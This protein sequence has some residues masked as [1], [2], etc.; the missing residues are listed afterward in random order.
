M[1]LNFSGSVAL[2]T[3]AG[4]GIGK[5]TAIAFAREGLK[6]VVADV[7]SQAGEACVA[8]I[9][10]QGGQALFVH[11][12][13][14]QDASVKAMIDATISAFGRLDYAFNNAGI[15]IEQGDRLPDGTDAEFDAIMNV[16]VKGV[17]NCLRHQLPLMMRQ[18]GGAIV[19][20]ASIA[21]L[22]AA[23]KM[24]IYA[25]SKHAVIGLTK[26]A[27]IEYARKK[28]RVNAVCPAVIDTEM[29]QRAHGGDEQYAAAIA[30]RHPVGR[31]GLPEEIAQAVLYLC[32]DGASF[33]TGHALPVDGGWVAL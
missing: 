24:S 4:A 27:A 23:P 7:N 14:T 25:A 8:D 18:G 3:G 5:A 26:S 16:N 21:G 2:V 9:N 31:V 28:V 20:T 11:C 1:A 12:D 17:W 29:H 19:N 6:V 22:C 13:V 32:S 33:T 30:A 15:E 10:A